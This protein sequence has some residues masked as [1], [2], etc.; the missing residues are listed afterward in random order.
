MRQT[1]FLPFQLEA[2]RAYLSQICTTQVQPPNVLLNDICHTSS[3]NIH[4]FTILLIFYNITRFT[5]DL[6]SY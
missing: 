3:I 2:L 4:D 1:V 5:T 6:Y